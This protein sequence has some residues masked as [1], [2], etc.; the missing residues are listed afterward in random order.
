MTERLSGPSVREPLLDPLTHEIIGAAIA[1]SKAFGP[2]LLESVYETC[3]VHELEK[4]HL[5]VCRQVS[6]PVVYDDLEIP[7]GFRAD[8]VIQGTVIVEI[9]TVK[10]LLPVHHAQLLTYMRLAGIRKGLLINFHAFP[11]SQGVKRLVI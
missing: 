8:L 10:N 2:G 1:V 9:K 11:F 7:L 5:Q 3:M 6:F 4:R